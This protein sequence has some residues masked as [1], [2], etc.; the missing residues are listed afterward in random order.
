[1]KDRFVALYALPLGP[2]RYARFIGDTAAEKLPIRPFWTSCLYFEDWQG[3]PSPKTAELCRRL[4]IDVLFIVHID[5]HDPRGRLLQ[6]ELHH[7]S[8]SAPTNPG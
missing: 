1:M 4:G 2:G 6:E 3:N 8:T 5:R 7:A